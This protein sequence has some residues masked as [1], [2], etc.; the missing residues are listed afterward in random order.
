[1]NGV[2]TDGGPSPEA[3]AYRSRYVPELD[4]LDFDD[5]EHIRADAKA[6]FADAVDR[7]IVRHELE[8]DDVNVGGVECLRVRSANGGTANGTLVYI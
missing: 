6:G 3:L 8:L 7:A 2:E 5:I 4:P 1:M